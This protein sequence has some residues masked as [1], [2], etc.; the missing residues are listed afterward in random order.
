MAR[1]KYGLLLE[2]IAISVS[3]AIVFT[4]IFL[5]FF[6]D[7]DNAKDSF[8][9]WGTA[10]GLIGL[11][12]SVDQLVKLR[13]EEEI[14]VDTLAEQKLLYI[15]RELRAIQSALTYKTIQEDILVDWVDRIENIQEEFS[16]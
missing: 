10:L 8:S 1:N 13:K 11:W 5:C 12:F 3:G 15:R 14:I 9:I 7:S 6:G 16:Y 2:W 4:G